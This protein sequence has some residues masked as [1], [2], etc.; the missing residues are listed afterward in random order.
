MPSRTLSAKLSSTKTCQ[1]E[2]VAKFSSSVSIDE[3]VEG[4][5]CKGG[6]I[7]FSSFKGWGKS[8]YFIIYI[9]GV[10]ACETKEINDQNDSTHELTTYI[11]TSVSIDSEALLTGD[12]DIEVVVIDNT[13]PYTDDVCSFRDGC[14][15]TI[16]ASYEA[17]ATK[18]GAPSNVKVSKT[19]SEDAVNLTWDAGSSGTNNNVTGYDVQYCDSADGSTWGSWT[20]ASGSPVTDTQLSVSP[21]STEGYYRKFRVRTRGSAGSSYYSSYVESSNTLRRSHEALEGFTD[22]TLTPKVSIVK[23]VYITELQDR[24][25]TLRSFYGLSSYSFTTCT[26]GVTKIAKWTDLINEIRT[27]LDETYTAAGETHADWIAF[28]VNCPRVDVL[29]QLRDA[30]MAL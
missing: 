12:G 29:Q 15:I 21:P 19:F 24:I 11:D 16:E 10:E 13:S 14:K 30:V 5:K 25:N 7:T 26:A 2:D 3:A 8:Y 6:E 18:V 23:A 17:T 4:A 1:H 9:D 20:T 28:D 27:A 22:P